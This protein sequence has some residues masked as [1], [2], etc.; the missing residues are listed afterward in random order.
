MKPGS[1][2]TRPPWWALVSASAA[3]VLLI[4]GW[5]IAAGRQPDF[6]SVH[7]TISALAA[8]GAHDRWLMTSAL[9]G[10]GVCH[11][12]TAAGLREARTPGRLL[13]ALGGVATV[14]VAAFPLPAEGGSSA[15]AAAAGTAFVALA[16]W[17]ALAW[18][19]DADAV[20]LRPKPAMTA[21]GGLLALVA[22][23]GASLSTDAV[24]LTER[25]AAGAQA[26]WPLA[27]VVSAWR[28]RRR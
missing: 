7:D 28:A 8:H 25:V 4:G 26:L 2:S 27:V 14:L 17:P 13:Q 5:T 22:A 18:R 6:N 11:V 24:G 3:P 1:P 19:R 15:H 20:L 21:A 23:F 9:A 12:I 10:L 16:A